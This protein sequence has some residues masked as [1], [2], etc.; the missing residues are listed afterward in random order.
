VA[1]GLSGDTYNWKARFRSEAT[2]D[3][4][5]FFTCAAYGRVDLSRRAL[6]ELLTDAPARKQAALL[7]RLVALSEL[8]PDKELDDLVERVV[9]SPNDEIRCQGAR[10][11]LRLYPQS[12]TAVAA[13]RRA[14]HGRCWDELSVDAERYPAKA[15]AGK[16]SQ[17]AMNYLE[18]VRAL[19]LDAFSAKVGVRAK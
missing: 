14:I 10:I 12:P 13:V 7:R 17:S 11:A 9:Q 18:Q 19:Q 3:E 15:V 1:S 4:E 5:Q 8:A 6:I 2:S 16:I